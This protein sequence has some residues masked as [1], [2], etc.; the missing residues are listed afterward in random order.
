MGWRRSPPPPPPASSSAILEPL[1]LP[2]IAADANPDPYPQHRP[3]SPTAGSGTVPAP[4]PPPSAATAQAPSS[5]TPGNL[6]CHQP[7][8]AAIFHRPGRR[9]PRCPFSLP[10][11]PTHRRSDSPWRTSIGPGDQGPGNLGTLTPEP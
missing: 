3:S 11:R 1:P 4:P 7:F 9:H 2:S 10:S 5:P 8:S 6:P